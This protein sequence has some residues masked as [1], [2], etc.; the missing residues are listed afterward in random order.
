MPQA[1]KIKEDEPGK[2]WLLKGTTKRKRL[3][4]RLVIVIDR[5]FFHSKILQSLKIET[6]FKKRLILMKNSII[7]ETTRNQLK[8]KRF[9]LK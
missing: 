9:L 1:K 7:F 8:N 6:D 3:D 5:K 4:L 2:E